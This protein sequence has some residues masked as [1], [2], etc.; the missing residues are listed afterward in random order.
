[1]TRQREEDH[2]AIE[3]MIE[4]QFDPPLNDRFY[5]TYMMFYCLGTASLLPTNFFTT[6]TDYW[7]YKFRD[8]TNEFYTS[9]N[10]TTLQAE[11]VSDYSIVTHISNI[12]FIVLTLIFIKKVSMVKRIVAALCGSMIMFF[13]T[14]VFVQV[15][16][17]SWQ[18]G[19]FITTLVIAFILTG[20]CA[21]FTATLFEMVARFPPRY[22]IPIVSGYSVCG[23][24]AAALQ[25]I[26]LSLEASSNTTGLTY[27][28]IG[29]FF[30]VLTLTAFVA[31]LLTS[32]FF[33]TNLRKEV[34]E[35]MKTKVTKRAIF[36]LINKLKFYLISMFIVLGCSIMIHPAVTSLVVSIEKGNGNKWNDVF[37]VP[38]ITFFVYFVVDYIGRE[39]AAV[40]K[41]PSNGIVIL[42][43]SC[44]RIAFVPMLMLCNA[45][46]RSH[47]PVVFDKDYVYI[48]FIVI[49]SFTNGY[50]VNLCVIQVPTVTTK[51]EKE[52]SML[53]IMV[54]MLSALGICSLLSPAMVKA[55]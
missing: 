54:F 29:M 31:S 26:C 1:M 50:L 49:F 44:C 9:E 48:I 24:F 47:M 38:V 37:F 16:T 32:Q 41:K 10:R 6:A 18:L 4:E 23:V 33:R 34:E 51:E 30:I 15:N 25:I 7:M 42:I 45:Q 19:F 43:V 5:T 3:R 13:L 28:T 52:L 17:D 22:V 2:G 40:V 14:C 20:L 11:F 39:L 53:I 27:F 8:P 55:L 35:S 12:V 46:P 36:S 21:M